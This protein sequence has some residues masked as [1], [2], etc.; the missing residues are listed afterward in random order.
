[1]KLRGTGSVCSIIGCGERHRGRIGREQSGFWDEGGGSG[2]DNVLNIQAILQEGKSWVS[3]HGDVNSK[4]PITTMER[5][6]RSVNS[7]MPMTA[8]ERMGRR[9]L[10][11]VL[12]ILNTGE[13]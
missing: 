1:M 9:G 5:M 2:L 12:E 4:M 7:K 10:I 11:C 3:L 8:M 6:G 13:G